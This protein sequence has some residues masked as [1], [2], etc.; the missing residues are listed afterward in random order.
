MLLA[1]FISKQETKVI[2]SVRDRIQRELDALR[3]QLYDSAVI[4]V[5]QRMLDVLTAEL[6]SRGENT[7]ESWPENNHLPKRTT[8]TKP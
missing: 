2:I 1:E 5:K 7:D 8:P 3:Q 4:D 6:E